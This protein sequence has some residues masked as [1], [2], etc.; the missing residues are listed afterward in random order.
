MINLASQR[1]TLVSIY[2]INCMNKKKSHPYEYTL[3]H[4]Q[5]HTQTNTQENCGVTS[6]HVKKFRQIFDEIGGSQI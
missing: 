4:S 5:T 6:K 3:T 1:E 2:I